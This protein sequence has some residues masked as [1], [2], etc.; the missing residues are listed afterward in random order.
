MTTPTLT[1]GELTA[2]EGLDL[3]K[4]LMFVGGRHLTLDV[5]YRIVN[6]NTFEFVNNV[7]KNLLTIVEVP[8]GRCCKWD[9]RTETWSNV[10]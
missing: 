8:S 5:H 4:C 7:R 2:P 9:P 1:F 6:G 3:N 10:S